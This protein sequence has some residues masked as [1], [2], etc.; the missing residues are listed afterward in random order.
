MSRLEHQTLVLKSFE[1]SAKKAF[2]DSFVRA[3]NNIHLLSSGYVAIDGSVIM[4]KCD[5]VMRYEGYVCTLIEATAKNSL[6][7]HYRTKYSDEENN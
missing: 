4:A 2:G 6:I 7:L 3:T 1:E 5:T